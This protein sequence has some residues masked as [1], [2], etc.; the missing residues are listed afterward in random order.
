M[1]ITT[2]ILLQKL[3]TPHF[4]ICIEFVYV[5]IALSLEMGIK[6]ENLCYVFFL[7]INVVYISFMFLY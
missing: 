3:L 7:K 4:D 5:D 6:L 2:W 1:K